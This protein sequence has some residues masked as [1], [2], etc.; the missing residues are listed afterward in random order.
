MPAFGYSYCTNKSD[1]NRI[2]MR[3]CV[4]DVSINVSLPGIQEGREG[5]GGNLDRLCLRIGEAT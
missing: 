5:V 4:T 3:V 2:Q 1:F